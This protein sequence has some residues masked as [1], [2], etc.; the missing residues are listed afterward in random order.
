M[1]NYSVTGTNPDPLLLKD[2][3]V[4]FSRIVTLVL[5]FAGLMLFIMLIVGGIK[6]ITAGGEPKALESAR[7]TI[8]SAIAGIVLVALTYLILYFIEVFTGVNVTTFTIYR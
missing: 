1:D 5:G 2:L 6:Y 7:K 8:T 3:E 4:T